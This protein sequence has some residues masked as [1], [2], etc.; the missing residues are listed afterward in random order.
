MKKRDVEFME[1]NRCKCHGPD[2]EETPGLPQCL[3]CVKC[4]GW[5]TMRVSSLDELAKFREC[6]APVE[7]QPNEQL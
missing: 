3:R 6:F 1:A 2:L 7:A 4:K 5:F